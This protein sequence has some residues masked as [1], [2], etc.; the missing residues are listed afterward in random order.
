MKSR[1]RENKMIT[2]TMGKIVQLLPPA[3]VCLEDPIYVATDECGIVKICFSYGAALKHGGWNGTTKF[4]T[5]EQLEN[6]LFN[7]IDLK[8]VH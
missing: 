5:K 3:S 2:A 7:K 1:K 6:M 8:I 4:V